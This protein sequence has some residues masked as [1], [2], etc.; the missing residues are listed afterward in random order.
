[1]FGDFTLDLDRGCLWRAG[2]EVKLRHKSFEALK[3]LVGR[4]GRLVSKLEL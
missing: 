4:R 1:M 3:Y 2:Q